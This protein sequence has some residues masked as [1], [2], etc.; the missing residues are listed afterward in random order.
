VRWHCYRVLLI[1]DVIGQGLPA[2]SV[3]IVH[4]KGVPAPITLSGIVQNE[5][6]STVTTVL[7]CTFVFHLPYKLRS[8][9]SDCMITIATGKDIAVNVILGLP[10]ITEMNMVFDFNDSVAT[11]NTIDHQPFAIHLRRTARTVPVAAVGANM[12][13][14]VHPVVAELEDYEKWRPEQ[15]ALTH[16]YRTRRVC[17]RDAAI[18]SSVDVSLPTDSHSSMSKVQPI[19]HHNVQHS[20]DSM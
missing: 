8:D 12:G 6:L 11:C 2:L 10:F 16:S 15:V 5:N 18:D 14:P 3:Q 19:L 4:C 20:G 13:I 17:F 7:D 9:G 1:P